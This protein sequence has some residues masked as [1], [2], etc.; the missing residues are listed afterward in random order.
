MENRTK[1]EG[2]RRLVI[3]MSGASGAILGI[4]LLKVLKTI[5]EWESHLVISKGAEETIRLETDYSLD[6]VRS[7]ADK[8]YSIKDIGATIASGTF[9]TEGM[10]IIPCSMKT[11][12]G[13][14]GGYSDNL[15][16]R[17]ADVIIKERRKLVIIARESPFS[18]IHLKNMLYL[19]QLGAT[20]MPPMVT[21]YN[22][23]NDL[24]DMNRHIIG[25]ILDKLG[26]EIVGFKRWGETVI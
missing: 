8:V 19:D 16:L 11:V 7:L 21:Y 1:S 26:I 5:P 9:K 6:D 15:L 4:E 12:A 17:A 20:I 23:P 14:A 25:K 3:G 13:I 22:N 18:Q 2:N 10:I 24:N